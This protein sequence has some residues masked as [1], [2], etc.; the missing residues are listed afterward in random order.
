MFSA[1][2]LVNISKTI[3]NW[4][5]GRTF[6]GRA[7]ANLNF[8]YALSSMLPWTSKIRIKCFMCGY[9]RS[10]THWVRNVI[11]QSSSKKTYDL[12]ENI[13]KPGLDEALL[14]KIHARDRRIA[15]FKAKLSLPPHR[16]EG[17]YIYT[18]RDPRDTIISLFEM[19]KKAKKVSDLS[20]GQFI[21]FYDPIRQYRWEI[22]AWIAHNNKDVFLVRF[23][24]LK[25]NPF[26]GFEQIF[27]Y[28]GLDVPVNEESIDKKVATMD[29]TNRPRGAIFGW[30]NTYDQ[31]SEL[32]DIINNDMADEIK[33]LGYDPP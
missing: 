12:Y 2:K 15:Q 28:L 32:I 26:E 29:Q 4:S 7:G 16:F 33:I 13:P 3:L 18:Y 23:E 25:M 9:P 14:V 19:Y 8:K 17:K 5:A 21:K 27:R 6:R 1:N 24:D 30:K 10:G 11:E 31:Y 20:P 22:D